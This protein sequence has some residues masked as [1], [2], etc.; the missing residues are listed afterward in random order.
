MSK[1]V[2]DGN[3]GPA[4]RPGQEKG[5]ALVLTLLTISMLVVVV[6]AFTSVSRLEQAAARNFTYQAAAQQLASLATAEAMG[7]LAVAYDIATNAPMFASQPGRLV[8]FGGNPLPLYST[9]GSSVS[10]N[11]LLTNSNGHGWITG[12]QSALTV[13][14][15][16]VS[17]AAGVPQG[18]IA[19]YI[20]DESSKLPINFASGSATGATLNPQWPRPYSVLGIDGV[21]N[22]NAS[23]FQRILTNNAN[24]PSNASNW[25]FF[26]T[27]EQAKVALTNAGLREF[28]QITTANE[29]NPAVLGLTPWGAPK[30]RI[31]ELPLDDSGIQQ[32]AAALSDSN[33]ATVFGQHFGDKYG[34]LGLRQIAANLLQLRTAY[35]STNF[36][37]NAGAFGSVLA[38]PIVGLASQSLPQQPAPATSG[39]SK[40]T[41]GIPATA[42]GYAPFPMLSEVAV[43]GIQY[44]YTARNQMTVR[45]YVACEFFNPFP[46]PYNNPS[47]AELF[48]Q[49]DKARMRFT[50]TNTATTDPATTNQHIWRGPD[51]TSRSAAPGYNDMPGGTAATFW[52][53]WGGGG[54]RDTPTAT[55]RTLN[56]ASGYVSTRLP[57]SIPASNY[58]TVFVPFDISFPEGG[59]DRLFLN[60]N[61]YVIL[62]QVRVMARSND[63]QS[64]RDWCSG[65]D[66][67]N[68]L[69]DSA[70]GPAQ[71]LLP[72]PG[73]LVRQGS[74]GGGGFVPAPQ[75][76]TAAVTNP[77]LWASI[78]KR[79]PRL[80]PALGAMEFDP[81]NGA[82]LRATA[83]SLGSNN[84]QASPANYL[85]A[86]IPADPGFT[87][88]P[89]MALYNTNLPPLLS[90]QSATSRSF[91]MA[92]D[93]GKVFT[94]LPWRTLRMQP[95]PTNE[96]GLIPDW[97]L[98]DVV[99]FG[100]GT[101]AFTP[102]NPNAAMVSQ[103][104]SNSVRSAALK[105][106]LY[107][108]VLSNA[109]TNVMNPL[110]NTN[111]RII[112]S[113]TIV[114]L[115][116]IASNA[117]G[118]LATN[119]QRPNIPTSWS[120]N[121]SWPGQRQ[122]LGFPADVLLIPSE[123]AE[124]RHFA[125]FAVTDSFKANEY[126]IS[127]LFPGLTTRSRFFRIYAA[128]EAFE[129]TNSNA[130]VAASAFLQT[131]VEVDTSQSPP[132]IRT[133]NQ[134]PPAE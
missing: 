108:I 106:A 66:F 62:D 7:K 69:A 37:L 53:P 25:A 67:R 20:D 5:I 4:V 3:A 99:D 64:I 79:D 19:Y 58:A 8:P 103:Q 71:F 44:G 111:S 50:N 85:A 101:R 113:P 87:N 96:N 77:A 65:P 17:N 88:S 14:T 16:T 120:A 74:P 36:Y 30:L 59:S 112:A 6:V 116:R 52:D 91:A 26:F 104:A 129:G 61:A 39:L 80:R 95:Q 84:T 133:V 130:P 12:E 54:N 22:A 134:Y 75:P 45:F 109:V 114:N 11:R 117:L 72:I 31:N 123:I 35:W 86:R 27:P 107:P 92:A 1:T 2:R 23:N 121:S 127:A 9:G 28:S 49:I 122:A 33:L 68:A 98:L 46:V 32:I 126:R 76:A 43:G 90:S 48:V 100:N 70:Q 10:I 82:W 56:P 118:Q 42:V 115:V 78:I 97:V 125:D 89:A 40:K 21:G 102:V 83:S 29:T 18:R 93:L 128:G 41:T 73:N 60:T 81:A 131:L 94:G 34:T 124:I 132:A 110:T 119:A 105:G 55:I 13:Q 15:I 24:N 63:V 38:D 51:G 57:A 47:G